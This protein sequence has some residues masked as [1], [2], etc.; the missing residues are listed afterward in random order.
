MKRKAWKRSTGGNCVTNKKGNVHIAVRGKAAPAYARLVETLL[1]KMEREMCSPG[2]DLAEVVNE[3]VG[4]PALIEFILQ[5]GWTL[6]A[7]HGPHRTYTCGPLEICVDGEG[8]VAWPSDYVSVVA[9]S[10]R[11]TELEI[12]R[13]MAERERR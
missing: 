10:L 7:R 2:W 4:V 1:N 5:N 13:R 11:C 8:R 6:M 3:C 12:L 9:L